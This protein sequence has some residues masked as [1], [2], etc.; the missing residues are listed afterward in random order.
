MADEAYRDLDARLLRAVNSQDLFRVVIRGFGVIEDV[1]ERGI[2]GMLSAPL[3]GLATAPFRRNLN[4]AVGLGLV[5]PARRAAFSELAKLRNQLAHA[6]R[7]PE[8]VTVSELEALFSAMDPDRSALT[9]FSTAE[10]A[11]AAW[12]A[13]A[14]IIAAY[15]DVR[16]GGRVAIEMRE[17]E[18][19]ALQRELS[20]HGM[21]SPIIRA[22]L[23]QDADDVTGRTGAQTGAQD[24]ETA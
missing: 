8:D 22:L 10:P 6:D 12:W 1:L 5:A 14:A 4:L 15:A 17:R 23:K 21:V 18:R 7:E 9:W 3:E 24:D 11:T 20:T 16:A 2:E 13:G 19:E